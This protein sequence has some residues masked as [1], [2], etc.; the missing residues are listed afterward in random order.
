MV[1][2]LVRMSPDPSQTS[3]HKG[4]ETI[5][6]LDF[7]SQ[8]SQLIARRVR[9]AGAFSLLVSPETPIEEK[10]NDTRY[11]GTGRHGDLV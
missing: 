7:G 1:P 2:C 8:Y 6:I 4:V 10:T 9:E 11:Q 3:E 5:L